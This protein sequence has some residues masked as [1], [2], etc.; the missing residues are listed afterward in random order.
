MEWLVV[1]GIVVVGIACWVFL[2]RSRAKGEAGLTPEERAKKRA[3]EDM[4]DRMGPLP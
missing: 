1:A 4:A 2:E 3:L